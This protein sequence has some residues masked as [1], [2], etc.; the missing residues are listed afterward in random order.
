MFIA[1][2]SIRQT[3]VVRN[4]SVL[5]NVISTVCLFCSIRWLELLH[6]DWKSHNYRLNGW[7]KTKVPEIFSSQ[8]MS[9]CAFFVDVHVNLFKIEATDK[10]RKFVQWQRRRELDC[11][12][13][14]R[15]SARRRRNTILRGIY[16]IRRKCKMPF[17]RRV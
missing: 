15:T 6:F 10:K 13:Y 14:Q 1:S 16:T 4:D 11:R 3:L 8:Q 7:N 5:R 17:T 12:L 2:M 9:A